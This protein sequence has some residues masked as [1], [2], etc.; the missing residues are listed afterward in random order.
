LKPPRRP[1]KQV[2]TDHLKKGVARVTRREKKKKT[3]ENLQINKI[4]KKQVHL[5][6]IKIPV[7]Y[8]ERRGEPTAK[9]GR[10]RNH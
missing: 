2:G 7:C 8:R 5:K 10:R 6:L 4:L 9:Q 3:E 1:K